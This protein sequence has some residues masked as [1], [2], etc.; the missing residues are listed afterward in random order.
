MHGRFVLRVN[1]YD[2]RSSAV[3][4]GRHELRV[5]KYI[6]CMSVYRSAPGLIAEYRQAGRVLAW[7][8]RVRISGPEHELSPASRGAGGG[9]AGIRANEGVSIVCRGD[10]SAGCPKPPG[11]D[12]LGNVV[13]GV[14]WSDV[15]ALHD[16]GW[17]V[18][19]R[20]RLVCRRPSG[21]NTRSRSS[22]S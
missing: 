7:A 22:L 8:R 2:H 19:P 9:A 17:H 20:G 12:P 5:S 21:T 14:R 16:G 3:L 4:A 1:R 15:I 11:G 6:S 10:H 13:W 18:D